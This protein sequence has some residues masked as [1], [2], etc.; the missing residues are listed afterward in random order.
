MISAV[1]D[2]RK[3][4]N[5]KGNMWYTSLVTP[6]LQ[7]LLISGEILFAGPHCPPGWIRTER[8][9]SIRAHAQVSEVA[10]FGISY[11]WSQENE[12]LFGQSSNCQRLGP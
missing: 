3:T 2:A 7:A 12:L 9:A 6:V 8:N 10:H 5:V 1:V 4:G 11:I